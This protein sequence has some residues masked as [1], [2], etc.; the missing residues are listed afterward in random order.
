MDARTPVLAGVGMVEQREEDPARAAEPLELMRRAVAAAGDDAGA[1]ALLAQVGLVS[2]PQGQWHHVDPGRQFGPRTLVAR[3]GVLQQTVIGDACR[4]IAEGEVDVALVIGAEARYRALRARILGVGAPE[5]PLGGEPD[6]LWEFS[7]TLVLESEVRGGLGPMPV[8][9]YAIIESALRAAEGL[10]VDAHRDRLAALYSRFS[11]IATDNPHAWKRDAV[12]A[13]FIRDASEKNPMLAF[14]YT[15]LHNSSWNVDQATALLLCS[16]EAAERAG[17]ARSQWVFPRV[18]AESNHALALSERPD[19]ADVPGV[20]VAGRRAYERA[21]IEAGDLDLVELYSCFPVA[22]RT[23]ARE[24]GIGDDIDWTVTGGMPFAGGPFNSY[25]LQATGRMAERLRAEGDGATG[26][27]SSVS[28][29]L[30]KHGVAIWSTAPGPHPF[31]LVDVTDE[32][33]ATTPARSVVSGATGGATVAGC[34]VMYDGASRHGVA[35]VDLDT[36]DR[37][38]VRTDDPEFTESMEAEEWVGRRVSVDQGMLQRPA[39][40]G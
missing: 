20:R 25:V 31:A 32:V 26:L 8:G 38:L 4:R 2:M 17:V 9:Y 27:V 18:S 35:L 36:G 11:E 30:T 40:A 3:V 14:P 10:T 7:G 1:P 6:E 33:A 28:G 24:L 34:T 13:D 19:L 16:A 22:V 39:G 29:L 21:G 37:S 5:S 12:P 15:K 23:H